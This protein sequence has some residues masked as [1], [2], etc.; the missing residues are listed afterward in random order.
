MPEELKALSKEQAAELLGCKIR[1]VELYQQ[2]GKLSVKYVKGERGKKAQYDR[3]EVLA[4]KESLSTTTEAYQQRPSLA[5]QAASLANPIASNEAI[6]A[7]ALAVSAA[8]GPI[9][10]NGKMSLSFEEAS[11]VSGY[12]AA[13]LKRAM[14]EKELPYTTDGPHRSIRIKCAD[15]NR[16]VDSL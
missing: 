14:A 7:L 4:L 2:Q 6:Q 10:I 15:L 9:L 16:W 13:R 1:T 5:L 8:R 3:E 11:E 12:S